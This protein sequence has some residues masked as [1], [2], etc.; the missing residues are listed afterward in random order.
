VG[1]AGPAGVGAGELGGGA[2]QLLPVRGGERYD[3]CAGS[4]EV[5]DVFPGWD[6]VGLCVSTIL[7]QYQREV[8][9]AG[10]VQGYNE[11]DKQS[12]EPSEL[13]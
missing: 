9:D 12:S 13:E 7:L 1:G 10:S 5:W 4:G 6:G 3:H 2:V 11:G 8:L